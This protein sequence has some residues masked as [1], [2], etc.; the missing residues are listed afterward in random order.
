MHCERH[1]QQQQKRVHIATRQATNINTT[2]T[3]HLCS[4]PLIGPRCPKP[5]AIVLI[6][7][8]FQQQQYA[9]RPDASPSAWHVAPSAH[10]LSSIRSDRIRPSDMDCDI[11]RAHQASGMIRGGGVLCS[12]RMGQYGDF[13]CVWRRRVSWRVVI[14]MV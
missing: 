12:V 1:K 6:S 5:D 7:T 2:T 9:E 11:A 4:A 14:V 8:C 13:A 10:W 3:A